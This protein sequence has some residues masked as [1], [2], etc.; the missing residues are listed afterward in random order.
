MSD[1]RVAN[2][3]KVIYAVLVSPND[4][5]PYEATGDGGG[6][7]GDAS[8][9]NQTTL[10]NAVGAGADAAASSDTGTFSIIAFIK[11]GMQNWTTLLGKIATL[12]NN[13]Y[14]VTDALNLAGN[15]RADLALTTSAAQTASVLT[16]GRYA[17]S[18]SA[19]CFIKVNA[20]ASDVTTANGYPLK[21]NTVEFLNFSGSEKLGGI[22]A[23][24]TATLSYHKVS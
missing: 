4:G 8:A 13:S 9:A 18:T 15:A 6:G 11:R 2:G 3:E 10:N 7:G 22:V 16:A 5:E 21:A 23:T 12:S 17:V 20:T 24:G 14:P 1:Y 19:D